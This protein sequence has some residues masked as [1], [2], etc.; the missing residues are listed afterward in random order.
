MQRLEL[1]DRRDSET[2]VQGEEGDQGIAFSD[3][4][5]NFGRSIWVCSIG[6]QF[7]YI[8]GSECRG[9]KCVFGC[10]V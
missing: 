7:R 1:H 6:G 8:I 2:D 5:N 9:I 10:V 3:A 4:F